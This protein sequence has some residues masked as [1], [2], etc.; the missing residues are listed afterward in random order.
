MEFAYHIIHCENHLDET[1]K[2]QRLLNM[3][4]IRDRIFGDPVIHIFDAVDGNDFGPNIQQYVQSY[5][6]QLYVSFD[7]HMTNCEIG[8]YLSH[9]LLAK[10]GL[11]MESEFSVILE[12]DALILSEDLHSDILEIARETD[13]DIIFLGNLNAHKGAHYRDN[14]YFLDETPCWGTHA[15]LLN[16]K[17]AGK[18]C[19]QLRH[20]NIPIDN[21]YTDLI[22]SGKLTGFV[23][24]PV[25]SMPFAGKSTIHG[26]S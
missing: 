19:E 3:Q 12:D 18:I 7:N 15:L 26:P 17:N 10:Q 8:C 16:N 22:R 25:L 20:I 23:I 14:I 9:Y 2:E 13:F 4:Q 21:K 6:P 5:D 11:L 24:Y 1:T